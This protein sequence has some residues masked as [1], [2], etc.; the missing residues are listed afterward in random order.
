MS[1]VFFLPLL[2]AALSALLVPALASLPFMP[3]ALYSLLVSPFL[4][5]LFWVTLLLVPLPMQGFSS[6][7]AFLPLGGC[8]VLIDLFCWPEYKRLNSLEG[9]ILHLLLRYVPKSTVGHVLV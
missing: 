2:V 5:H 7:A 9:F 1:C 6:S 3:A 8:F 4:G